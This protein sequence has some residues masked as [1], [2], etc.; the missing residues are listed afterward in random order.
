MKWLALKTVQSVAKTG[1]PIAHS[2][3]RFCT[4]ELL[5]AKVARFA[6]D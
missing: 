5:N 2:L 6:Q 3:Q 1:K 4:S